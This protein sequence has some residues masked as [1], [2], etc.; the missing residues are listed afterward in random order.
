[1]KSKQKVQPDLNRLM[2]SHHLHGLK[3]MEKSHLVLIY[4]SKGNEQV[5]AKG[6][7]LPKLEIV[8]PSEAERRHGSK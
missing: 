6:D 3:V 2:V 4:T 5:V 7:S 1:M 8:D